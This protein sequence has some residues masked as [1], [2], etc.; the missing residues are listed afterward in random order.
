MEQ[1]SGESLMT[2][3]NFGDSCLSYVQ[4]ILC[5]SKAGILEKRSWKRVRL[6]VELLSPDFKF[7]LR[8]LRSY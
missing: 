1:V 5:P 4:G 6:G 8:C 2:E 3:V 7:Q